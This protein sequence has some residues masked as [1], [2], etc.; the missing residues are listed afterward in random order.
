MTLWFAVHQSTMSKRTLF[1]AVLFVLSQFLLVDTQADSRPTGVYG[2]DPKRT[3]TDIGTDL[4]R[5]LGANQRKALAAS[6][7]TFNDDP[8]P[9]VR[10]AEV[11][12]GGASAGF[13]IVTAGFIDLCRNVSHAKAI[14]VVDKG[15][16]DRYI[17]I[18]S[19]ETGATGLRP[20]PDVDNPRYWS[21]SVMN[22]QQTNLRQ[23]VG[24]VVG[25][26]LAHHYL[27]HFKKYSAKIL[28]AQGHRTPINNL[29]SPSEFE[30]ALL[31][32]TRLSLDTGLGLE[33]CKAL[34]DAIGRMEKRPAW[35]AS[36][37]PESAKIKPL[38]KQ[39]EKV[40]RK[41]FGGEE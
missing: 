25:T 14:D 37:L 21:T 13:V 6:P 33:G 3:V 15:Y 19:D 40:E 9:A 22:E 29:L 28:D 16:F 30:E 18:L 35:T 17:H 11:Q 12:E 41:F 8:A 10:L 32:G 39:M 31:S 7:V 23:M 36:F 26:K 38:K 2:F 24:L 20:L 27:G 5:S 34:Y 1:A 4:R